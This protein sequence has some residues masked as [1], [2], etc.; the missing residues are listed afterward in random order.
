MSFYDVGVVLNK[1]KVKKNNRN[2]RKKEHP[3]RDSNS[4]SSA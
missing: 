4:E 3:T 2:E 1:N